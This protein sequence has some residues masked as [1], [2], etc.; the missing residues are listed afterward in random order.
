MNFL[1][2]QSEF[3]IRYYLWANSEFER[4]ING[5]FPSSQQ[6][7]TGPAW[8]AFQFFQKLDNVDRLVLARGLLKR[9]HP[10]AVKVLGETCSTDEEILRKRLDRF[11]HDARSSIELEIDARERSG[12]KI[13]YI[14]KRKLLNTVAHRFRDVFGNECVESGRELTGDPRLEFERKCPGG[15]TISTH[16]WFGRGESLIDYS[17]AIS[18]EIAVE[19]RGAKG[20]YMGS[21]VMCCLTSFCSWLGLC[22]QT[23]WEYLANDQEVDQAC[24]AAIKLCS[25][26]FA[27]APKLMNGLEFEKISKDGVACINQ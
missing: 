20:P 23:Q 26:F 17:H 21:L 14:S 2:A 13:R 1:E 5:S 8:Q 15:W 9:F 12:E 11:R 7:R 19:Q 6:F 27:V 25:H 18:S 10:E 24:N 16:F 4:E 3:R 22:S